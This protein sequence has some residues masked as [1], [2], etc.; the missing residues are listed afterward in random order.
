MVLQTEVQELKIIKH[1]GVMLLW[2]Y[3]KVRTAVRKYDGACPYFR[4]VNYLNTSQFLRVGIK[5]KKYLAIIGIPFLLSC[6]DESK[7]LSDKVSPQPPAISSSVSPQP[8]A[9]SSS[10]TATQDQRD[11][12]NGPPSISHLF[13]AYKGIREEV[14]G[15]GLGDPSVKRM[16]DNGERE[17]K[18]AR[19]LH[20][21]CKNGVDYLLANQLSIN[22]INFITEALVRQEEAK[23]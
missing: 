15:N 14:E 13:N 6:G 17:Y 22:S 16:Y 23:K 5:M 19:E 18:R 20:D 3:P 8:P 9:I 21:T 4:L 7:D 12:C 2:V 1:N 10:K 11:Y